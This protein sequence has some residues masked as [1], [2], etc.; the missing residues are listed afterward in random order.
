MNVTEAARII[1]NSL[2]DDAQHL[3]PHIAAALD[4]LGLLQYAGLLPQPASQQQ[5]QSHEL[6][7]THHRTDP[8]T[9]SAPHPTTTSG[10]SA[11]GTADASWQRQPEYPP[12]HPA[13]GD[14]GSV[15]L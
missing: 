1:N 11:K 6:A 12:D 3:A 7:A 9:V 4:A 10:T 8:D 13:P 15:P 5:N 14:L 2:A